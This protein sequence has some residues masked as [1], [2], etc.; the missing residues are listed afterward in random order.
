MQTV[1]ERERAKRRTIR[2]KAYTRQVRRR[3]Q[4]ADIIA[5]YT[6]TFGAGFIVGGAP[7]WFP[8][9]AKALGH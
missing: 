7:L 4:T 5:A 6:L 1:Y 9:L 2:A 3:Y 8:L